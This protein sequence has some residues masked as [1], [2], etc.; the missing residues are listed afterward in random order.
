MERK[1]LTAPSSFGSTCSK[2]IYWVRI[3]VIGLT[4]TRFCRSILFSVL[5]AAECSEYFW[6]WMLREVQGIAASIDDWK[7][8]WVCKIIFLVDHSLS[9]AMTAEQ[10]SMTGFGSLV[11]GL[12]LVSENCSMIKKWVTL[13]I[14]VTQT[15]PVATSVVWTQHSDR[16]KNRLFTKCD[17]AEY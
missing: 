13:S 3:P 5:F 8:L 9:V 17:D 4:T 16:F 11:G 2:W 6:R 15:E 12:R 7:M 14:L 10:S 1:N